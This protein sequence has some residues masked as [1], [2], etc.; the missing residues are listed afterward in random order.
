[1]YSGKSE[2]AVF[3]GAEEPDSADVILKPQPADLP[4]DTI[5]ALDD[6]S[7]PFAFSGLTLS[8]YTFHSSEAALLTDLRHW[9]Q[10]FFA[11]V[12]QYDTRT[13]LPS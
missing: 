1:M 12:Y 2:W 13:R 10:Q 9:S 3:H 11:Q 6:I 7:Q 5:A 8:G 4:E